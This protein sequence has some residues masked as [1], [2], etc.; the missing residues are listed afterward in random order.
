MKTYPRI[1][2]LAAA[3]ACLSLGFVSTPAVR[4]EDAATSQPAKQDAIDFRKMKAVMPETLVGIKREKI[5]GQKNKIGDQSFSTANADYGTGDGDNAKTAKI[6]VIDYSSPDFAKSMAVWMA[7]DIDQ[8]TDDS[9]TKT[10]DIQGRKALI[11]YNKANKTGSVQTL[12]GNRIMVQFE[13]Q[14]LTDEE[15]N[16]AFA[17]LPLKALDELVK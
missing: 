16:K 14:N 3:V 4:A 7:T 6:M 5:E 10:A 2:C 1:V 8:E 13:T 15:F 17:E 11:T 9:Y 12:A